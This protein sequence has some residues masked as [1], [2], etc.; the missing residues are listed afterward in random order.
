MPTNDSVHAPACVLLVEDEA[1]IAMQLSMLLED[2]GISVCGVA[3]AAAQA[4]DLA[5]KAQPRAAVVD[6][7]LGP[8]PDGIEVAR[9][10]QDLYRCRI[11]FVS[12][13]GERETVDRA[14]TIEGSVFM[15]KPVDPD[16]L[17]RRLKELFAA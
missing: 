17:I 9:H 16:A 7:R 3:A 2:A 14:R 11:I 1:L 13:S 12:G 4:M 6:I 8:G 5:A 15:Q 10:L